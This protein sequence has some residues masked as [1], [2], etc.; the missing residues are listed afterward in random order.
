LGNT[1]ISCVAEGAGGGF[2]TRR[3]GADS[4]RSIF[5]NCDVEVRGQSIIDAPAMVINSSIA[6]FVGNAVVLNAS[7]DGT[8]FSSEVA[9]VSAPFRLPS[10]A[11]AGTGRQVVARLGA[12]ERILTALSLSVVEG[13]IDTE[14]NFTGRPLAV[15]NVG[16]LELIYGY[17]VPGWW[18]LYWGRLNGSPLRI[19][20]REAVPDVGEAQIWCELGIFFGSTMV[21][22][23][24]SGSTD[25]APPSR[26]GRNAGDIEFN[27]DPQVGGHVGWVWVVPPGS[28]GSWKQFGKIEP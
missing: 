14:S 27:S 3:V 22:V 4:A 10:P 2:N 23:T 16:N 13:T 11:P 19:S 26:L 25:T 28:T 21:H 18:G 7:A 6:N 8:G 1:Y 5:I 9:A 12:H 24:A 17:L 20:T 15:S